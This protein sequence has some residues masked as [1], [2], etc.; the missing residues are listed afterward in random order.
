MSTHKEK[1]MEKA[2]TPFERST[3]FVYS[4]AEGLCSSYVLLNYIPV[5]EDLEQQSIAAGM[6]GDMQLMASLAHIQ[7]TLKQQVSAFAFEA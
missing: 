5:L 4:L 1:T 3:E 7:S 6:R 2:L